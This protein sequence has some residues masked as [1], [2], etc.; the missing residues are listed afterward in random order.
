MEL[1]ARRHGRLLRFDSR[2]RRRSGRNRWGVMCGESYDADYCE[3]DGEGDAHL[4]C[5]GGCAEL[6]EAIDVDEADADVL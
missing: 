3:G 1:W 2:H 4:S 5:R 6:R